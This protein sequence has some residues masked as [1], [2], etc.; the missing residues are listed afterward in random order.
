MTSTTSDEPTSRPKATG[1]KPKVTI[2]DNRE[3]LYKPEN[4]R[5]FDFS[6]DL[7][8]DGGLDIG[9]GTYH[10]KLTNVIDK[11]QDNEWETC[12]DGLRDFLKFAG[13]INWDADLGQRFIPIIS[14]KLVDFFKSPRSNLCRTACQTAGEFFNVA[15]STKRPEYDEMVDIL[16]CKTADPN[17]FIQKDAI[18][19]LD[20]MATSICLHHSVRA[21]CSKGPE[22]K[23]PVVRAST[24]RLLFII[25]KHQGVENIV[26]SDA[27]ARTRKRV[28]TNLAKF[29]MDKNLETRRHAEKL[30]ILL[31]PH[32][33]F[34]DYFFK[35]ID[36]NFKCPLRKILNSLDTK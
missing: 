7:S 6:S 15:K 11:L 29:L 28:L 26:G 12:V 27:N 20:K 25:C 16:L 23:N 32:K 22:H 34:V 14:R 10:T 8:T 30:C 13:N 17:R 36:N 21:I 18:V 5:N 19:A 35:D 33:F 31:K 9:C 2:V 3:L 24:A 4:L 1:T